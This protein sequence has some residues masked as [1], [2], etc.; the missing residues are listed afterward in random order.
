MLDFFKAAAAILIPIFVVS[1]MLNVGLTQRPTKIVGH[2]KRNRA[3]FARMVVTNLLLVPAL[4][5]FA[6]ELVE[7]DPAYA[8]GL[9]VFSVS[10]GAPF[11]IKLT[12]TSQHDLALGATVLMVLMVA[13][14]VLMPLLLPLLIEGVSVDTGAIIV[15]LLKQMVAPMVIGMVLLEWLEPVAA[16]LQ[17]IVAWVANISLYGMIVAIL[18]GYLREMTD[19]QLWLATAVGMVVLALGFF[20]GF[21]MGDGHDHLKDL[22]GLGTAG[23]GTAA[24]MIVAAENFTDPRVMV[25]ITIVNTLNVI[26]LVAVAK[27]LSRD[28]KFTPHD[29]I[30][31]DRP[32]RRPRNVATAVER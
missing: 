32:Q 29:P 10:A 17:P 28:N 11:M 9:I 24:A 3:F 7:L 23:R 18:V 19:P 16:P 26:G 31:A 22:G 27:Y 6:I 5:V 21:M 1:S 25:I 2:L 15:A 8:A 4:M 14:V 12:Q 13:T 20:V 30:A